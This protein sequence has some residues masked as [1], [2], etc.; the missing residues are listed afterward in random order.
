[1]RDGHVH[2]PYCPHGTTDSLKSYIE[3]AI[4]SGYHS[5]TFT[6][7][8]P[9]PPSFSD[10]VP[11][12]DSGMNSKKI[13]DYFT[14]IEKMKENYKKDIIIQKGLEVDYI[15]GFEEETKHFLDIYGPHMD[16]SILSVHFL[17]GKNNWYCIDYSPEM[18]RASMEDIG[19]NDHLY[20]KYFQTLKKSI[21][22]DLGEFKPKRI[23]HMTL[24]KKFHHLFPAPEQWKEYA[25]DFLEF[26]KSNDFSLDYN[27]AGTKKPHCKET[28]PPLNLARRASSMGIPLIYGSDAHKSS[29]ITQ[30][31]D[32]I[33]EKL[34]T[35]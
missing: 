4:Q 5:L 16:D 10:P 25:V 20:Q 15:E 13:D 18:Y 3:K 9:L 30:G 27:G 32:D 24:V 33:D 7:H 2:S 1:M 31:L 22:S 8:A 29:A 23:G 35:F 26:V 12:K 21:L 28:Y 11:E 17:K 6:E 34:L 14:D 19:S